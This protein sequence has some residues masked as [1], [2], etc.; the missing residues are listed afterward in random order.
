MT[1]IP[2]SRISSLVRE[3]NTE[4]K[5]VLREN[6]PKISGRHNSALVKHQGVTQIDQSEGAIVA[7]THTIGADPVS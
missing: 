7:T 2:I 1:S 4:V 6:K 3:L 5:Y